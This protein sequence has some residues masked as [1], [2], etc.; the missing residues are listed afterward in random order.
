MENRLGP[1]KNFSLPAL[2][3]DEQDMHEIATALQ[4]IQNHASELAAAPVAVRGTA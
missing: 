3:G 4:K 2:L 1:A